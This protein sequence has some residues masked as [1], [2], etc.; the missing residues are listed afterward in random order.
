[1][2]RWIADRFTRAKVP[3]AVVGI[4]KPKTS[5]GPDVEVYVGYFEELVSRC[6]RANALVP[7]EQCQ[8]L[9]GKPPL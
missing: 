4:P 7:L 8:S 9:V 5:S 3:R 6:L 1:M 2:F